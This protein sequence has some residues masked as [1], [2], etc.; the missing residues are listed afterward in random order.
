M[1][2]F[3][4]GIHAH[5]TL[6]AN[7]CTLHANSCTIYSNLFLSCADSR[8]MTPLSKD[9][10]KPGSAASVDSTPN[11]KKKEYVRSPGELLCVC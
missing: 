6:L 10:Q 2:A 4:N 5:A 9:R 1:H 3:S 7:S 11:G 8:Q